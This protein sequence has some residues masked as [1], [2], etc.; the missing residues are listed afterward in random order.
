MPSEEGQKA[1]VSPRPAPPPAPVPGPTRENDATQKVAAW[2]SVEIWEVEQ[3]DTAGA[4]TGLLL[5]LGAGGDGGSCQ[6]DK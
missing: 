2:L 1:R 4:G 6:T 3:R 5:I